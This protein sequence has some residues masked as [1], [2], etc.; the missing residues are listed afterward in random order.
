MPVTM[1]TEALAPM[2]SAP[3]AIIFSASSRERT[4]PE[5]SPDP[6][7]QAAADAAQEAFVRAYAA[8]GSFDPAQRFDVWVLRIARN[9]CYDQLR[10]KGF[11]PALDEE[12]TVAAVDLSPSVEA[13]LEQAQAIRDL[14]SALEK[15]PPRDREILALYYVQRR[16]TRDIAEIV[17][18][19]PGTIMARLFRAR[20]KLRE[21][22]AE[23]A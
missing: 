4:P 6:A 9:L 18:T 12:A 3:A 19:A 22:L 15:L 2:R 10:R 20:A 8:L 17:G 1:A 23:A 11:Q 7:A 13:R 5:A 16:T 21:L 14:E